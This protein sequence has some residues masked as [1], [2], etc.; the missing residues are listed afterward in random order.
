M[1]VAMSSS[2]KVGNHYSGKLGRQYFSYQE[3]LSG[4]VAKLNRR[5]FAETVGPEDVVIDFGCGSGHLLASL[6]TRQSIG[7]EVNEA[8]RAAAS[9]RG[10]ETV[11]SSDE[12]EAEVADVVISSHALE[13]ARAP[14]AELVSLRRLIKPGGQLVMMLPLD[15][16]RGQREMH[17]D[18]NHHLYAWTPLTLGNLLTEAGYRVD[19]CSIVTRAVPTR[20]GLARSPRPISDLA[21]IA[22]AVVRRRRQIF[23]KA[24]RN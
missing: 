21:E 9:K 6:E 3:P 24:A 1:K 18:P 19:S 8:A 14:F 7:I 22:W 16:W 2:A 23:V 11:S 4:L 10:L 15:D 13:H 12:L 20:F 17:D 5:Y